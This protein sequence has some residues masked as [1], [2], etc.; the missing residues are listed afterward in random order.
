[1]PMSSE[2]SFS[3]S[4]L[5]WWQSLSKR[6]ARRRQRKMPFAGSSGNKWLEKV[7]DGARTTSAFSPTT[8]SSS[9]SARSSQLAS[10]AVSMTSSDFASPITWCSKAPLRIRYSRLNRNLMGVASAP[11][12]PVFLEWCAWKEW[13]RMRPRAAA[14][15]ARSSPFLQ[16]W[17]RSMKRR[18]R[19]GVREVFPVMRLSG[20]FSSRRIFETGVPRK[21]T[22]PRKS[23]LRRPARPLICRNICA[24]IWGKSP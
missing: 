21:Y 7:H 14:Q 22:W 13:C 6:P 4:S 17:Y 3:W 16:R 5:Y 23:K 11:L 8:S 19:E 15:R 24:S 1:M 10:T 20:E 9:L 12:R 18:E 2:C